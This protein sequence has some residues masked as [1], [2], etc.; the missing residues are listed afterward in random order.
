MSVSAAMHILLI[1][2]DRE[3]AAYLVKGLTESGHRVDLAAEGRQGLARAREGE[4]DAMIIDRMLP[5][6]DGLS[7]I[8]ALRAANDQ[9]PVL[10]LSALRRQ[11]RRDD[12]FRSGP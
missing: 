12:R 6:L 9:T 3:A 10:V 2:D 1:E 11:D 8:A 5:G 7:I 4:F